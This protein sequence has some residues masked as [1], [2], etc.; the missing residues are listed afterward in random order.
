MTQLK[1]NSF[2][3]LLMED[4]MDDSM[5]FSAAEAQASERAAFIRR[6]YAHLAGAILLFIVLEVIL[7][8]TGAAEAIAGTILGNSFSWL[9]VLGAFMLVS[10]IAERW[11]HS[12]TS[13]SMQYL[14][15]GL[16]IFAEAIIFVPLLFIAAYMTDSGMELIYNA[17][18]LTL[19][20]FTGLTF[21]V[22]TTKVDFSFLGSI[23][24]IAGFVALGVIVL[25][26]IFGF[27]LG[28][29]FS[30]IMVL[31]AA[32]AILYSTHNVLREY[33]T[34]Q[35]VAASLSLFAGVALLFWYILRIF[36][37]SDD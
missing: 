3:R 2:L 33:H 17:G 1:L 23:L 12:D 9:I 16:F 26:I 10:W 27:E 7:F 37:A 32:G 25:S 36:I 21:I 22:F 30:A 20:L 35:H 6:T 14:G 11:A 15:L 13:Q 24:K 34:S 19:F 4:I 31:F 29:L 8:K 18:L 5:Y 28:I